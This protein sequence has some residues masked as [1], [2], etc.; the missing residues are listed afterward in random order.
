MEISDFREP[1]H[2]KSIES[3]RGTKGREGKSEKGTMTKGEKRK[4]EKTEME[5]RGKG[6]MKKQNLHTGGHLTTYSLRLINPMP[7]HFTTAIYKCTFPLQCGSELQYIQL[8]LQFHF[9]IYLLLKEAI[10]KKTD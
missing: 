2:L 10:Y 5:K 8:Q 6:S 3:Q 7:L 4:R 9:Q 1:Q